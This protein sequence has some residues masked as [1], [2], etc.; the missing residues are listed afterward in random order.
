MRVKTMAESPSE[1]NRKALNRRQLLGWLSA[2][3]IGTVSF[4]RALAVQATSAQEVTVE[5]VKQAEWISGIELTE[6]QRNQ[7]AAG[8]TA[9]SV[10]LR[11]YDRLSLVMI[12]GRRSNCIFS[13]QLHGKLSQKGKVFTVLLKFLTLMRTAFLPL[14]QHDLLRRRN[15]SNTSYRNLSQAF[16]EVIILSSSSWNPTEEVAMEK[17]KL[18]DT[19]E[20]PF[21]LD[22]PLTGI[23]YEPRI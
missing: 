15:Q 8:L 2:T 16:E 11:H 6:D 10:T 12:R 21:S 13:R 5:M 1:K 18:I 7:T 23:P 4:H 22:T 20:S 3:G 17:A 19:K 14:R 9:L